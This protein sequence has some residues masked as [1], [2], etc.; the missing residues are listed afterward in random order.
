VKRLLARIKRSPAAGG[1]GED[2]G[3]FSSMYQEPPETPGT[4]TTWRDRAPQIGAQ[5]FDRRQAAEMFARLWGADRH[6]VALSAEE[7]AR[8]SQYL[9]FVQVPIG[10]EVIA[11]DELG[12]YMVIVLDGS[13]SVDRGQPWGSRARLAEAH[14]GDMLGEMSLLD[15]GARFSSCVTLG[16]CTLA[17]VD[18]RR[19]DEMINQEPRLGVALLAS[20]SRRLSLRLRQV[21]ARLSALLSQN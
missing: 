7:L 16:P 21:S 8:M 11:Q 12:D 6:V 3:F 18:A 10:Q 17:V 14:A 5:P 2:A 1:S 19:L 9:E 4:M 13:L 15:A 20:L